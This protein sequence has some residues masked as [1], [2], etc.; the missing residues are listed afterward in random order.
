MRL[1][2]AWLV[3]ALMSTTACFFTDAS[4]GRN[5]WASAHGLIPGA[6]FDT[7]AQVSLSQG[8]GQYAYDQITWGIPTSVGGDSVTA[9][10]LHDTRGRILYSFPD[11][12]PGRGYSLFGS[13]D[14]D[15]PIQIGTVLE[16]VGSGQTY[17]D[18]HTDSVPQGA[19]R[20]DLTAA[21]F[22]DWVSH[23]CD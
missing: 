13:T 3:I 2:L 11:M 20:V 18:I 15:S 22:Q 5:R 17:F 14:Y 21:D 23:T 4:C 7:I 19:V 10:H 9:V 16:R 8:D 1:T 6:V 12:F